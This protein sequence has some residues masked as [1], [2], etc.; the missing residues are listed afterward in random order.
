MKPERLWGVCYVFFASL[1]LTI[2][3]QLAPQSHL[4]LHEMLEP[5]PVA[6][7]ARPAWVPEDLSA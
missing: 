6:S 4:M 2:S 5:E 1:G 7:V 3:P